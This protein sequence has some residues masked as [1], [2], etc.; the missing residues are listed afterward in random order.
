MNTGILVNLNPVQSNGFFIGYPPSQKGYKCFDP[1]T[2]NMF[3]TMNVTFN[4][5][6]KRFEEG[7]RIWKGKIYAR[8]RDLIPQL[9]KESELSESQSTQT[10]KSLIDPNSL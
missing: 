3:V 2:K 5:I 8:R 1:N 10:G 7:N 4:E 6:G 9:N